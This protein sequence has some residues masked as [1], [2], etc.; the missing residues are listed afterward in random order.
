MTFLLLALAAF[1]P[2]P[3]LSDAPLPPPAPPRR[4]PAP[5]RQAP[6]GG[7]RMS[8][9]VALVRSNPHQAIDAAN[10][11][12]DGHG[13][14][15]ARECLGLAFVALEDWAAAGTAYESAAHEAEAAADVRRAD[16]WVQAGNAWL[17]AGQPLRA[18][19]DFDGALAVPGLADTKRAEA[20]L[21]R[22]RAQV[23][24]GHADIARQDIDQALRLAP[25]DGFAWYLSA[26]LARRA[27]DLTRAQAD[28]GHAIALAPND[29]DT[30]LLA[31]TI[32][33]L[34]GHLDEAERL[35]RRLVAAAPDSDAGREAAA[36][37]ATM[38][39]VEAPASPPAPATA[40]PH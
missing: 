14:A 18:L 38:H 12:L 33:G 10:A 17:A 23:A 22:A 8:E 36:S 7:T 5:P 34:A 15:P 26:A 39:E 31:G 28:I 20:E 6:Q 4:A 1:Q 32:A 25:T 35:Y 29:P 19:Q 13:G 27:N 2:P 40:S 24:L 21:D 3:L 9:C 11:W 30:I 16:F 37:L